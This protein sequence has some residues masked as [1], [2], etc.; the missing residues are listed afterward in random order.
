MAKVLD[1]R[2]VLGHVGTKGYAF[3]YSFGHVESR[4][5]VTKKHLFIC[6]LIKCR[7]ER[8]HPARSYTLYAAK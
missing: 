2:M 4:L 7:R 6:L 1:S 8:T 3:G 5:F